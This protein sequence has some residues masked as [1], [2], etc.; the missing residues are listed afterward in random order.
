MILKSELEYKVLGKNNFIDNRGV[1][2]NFE[3]TQKINLVAT[4]TSKKNTLRS[5]HYHPYQT[6]ECLLIKG[7]YVSVY[8]DLEIKNSIKE[9]HLINEGELVVTRPNVAHTMIFSKDTVFINL[10]KGDRDHDN[11]GKTHTIPYLL[12]NNNEKK[13]ITKYYKF[14]CR[15]CNKNDFFRLVSL[16][17]QPFA[18][19]FLK[20]ITT[21]DKYPLEVN[22]CKNCYNAQLSVSPDLNKIYRNYLYRSSISKEF[23]NHFYLATKKYAKI[24]KLNKKNF[25][26]DVGSND[27]VALLQFKNLGFKNLL[28]FEPSK[29]LSSECKKKGIRTIND[30]LKKKYALTNKSKADIILASNVFAHNDNLSQ[31]LKN[32][33][34]MSKKNGKIII[35][36][37][38]FIDTLKN[39]SFDNI[40]HEHFNYWTLTA[41]NNFFLS[42]KCKIFKAEKINTHGGSL[43]IYASINLRKKIDSSVAK[44][45][46]EEKLYGLNNIKLY[47][48]YKKKINTIKN[49][50]SKNITWL[51]KKYP[52]IVGYGA[53]AKATVAINF[54]KLEHGYINNIIDDNIS[55]HNR[56]IPGTKIKILHINKLPKKKIDCVIVFAWNNFQEIKDKNYNIANKFISVRDL[57]KKDFINSFR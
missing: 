7:Q 53:S 5:N 19:N 15:V 24:F 48:D 8:K 4:I 37:Q 42:H 32:I 55:K 27:G 11:Y 20:K 56:F 52:N 34:I 26:I 40:Y 30:F 1:I 13:F 14:N 18:N 44:I 29:Q 50:F 31:M 51:K 35:E 54:F 6:Q 43:R 21:I 9:T 49:N 16:G 41:L 2:S 36:V 3:L 38:Y 57:Y 17:Y 23:T 45:L 10:V 39:C 12:I 47:S 46:T 25:I 28:G 22:I 33:M